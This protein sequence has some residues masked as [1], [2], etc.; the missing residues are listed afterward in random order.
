MAGNSMSLLYQWFF[1][2]MW[3]NKDKALQLVLLLNNLAELGKLEEFLE[4][5]GA[6]AERDMNVREA[7]E[8]KGSTFYICLPLLN[9]VAKNAAPK[10]LV[11]STKKSLAVLASAL[12]TKLGKAKTKRTAK[13]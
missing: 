7:G 3:Q 2:L 13:Q 9:E 4:V 6:V 11:S 1:S 5:V 12:G 10:I 8:G